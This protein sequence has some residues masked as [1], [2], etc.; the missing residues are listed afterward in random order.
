VTAERKDAAVRSD[1][2]THN[3]ATLV[4]VPE[5]EPVRL[6]PAERMIIS[7]PAGGSLLR[8]TLR[9]LDPPEPEVH[10]ASQLNLFATRPGLPEGFEYRGDAISRAE[11]DALLAAF[12]ALDFKEFEFHGF[13]GKRKVVSFGWRYDFSR[14]EISRAEEI[15]SFLLPLRETA[16]RFAR[17]RPSDLQQVLVLQYPAGSGIGWHKDKAV[18]GT[19]VGF[20][21]LAPCLFRLRRKRGTGW[22][23]ASLPIEPRSAYLLQGPAR[24]EWEHSIP[25]VQGLRYSVT[26]RSLRA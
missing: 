15:P 16:A 23:R 22:E 5:C 19:V 9:E 13:L 18:F 10:M 26:F 4:R 7:F 20:S 14:Q 11:E 25:A 12:A 2:Q 1:V 8:P 17:L 3:S 6:A 24:S 21:L